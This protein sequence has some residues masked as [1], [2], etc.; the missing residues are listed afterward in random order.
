MQ[1]VS[2]VNGFD[3]QLRWG[4]VGESVIASF[5]IARGCH[6]LPVYEILEGQFKGPQFYTS[7]GNYVAPDILVFKEKK[8]SWIEAK[9]K[10]VFS[11]HRISK[12]WVT[13]IDLHHYRDY[14]CIAK[15]QPWPVWLMFLHTDKECHLRGEPWP[16]PT[17]LFGR[18]I[19]ELE[20]RENHR[21][22]NHGK[23]GMV[24]WAHKKLKLISTIEQL[25][26]F[27]FM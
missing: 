17:G 4:K 21:H 6:V 13:G 25:K 9:R 23:T 24:Y 15:S 12:K 2:S 11:W 7:S 26:E 3:E 16:C 10:S 27:G 20:T 1:L 19:L 5:L 18:D 14:L 8:I 22:K